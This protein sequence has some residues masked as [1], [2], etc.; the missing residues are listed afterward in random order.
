[1]LL[2]AP[3][4]PPVGLPLESAV[5]SSPERHRHRQAHGQA[6]GQYHGQAQGQAHGQDQGDQS[7]FGG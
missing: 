1:M 5:I 2:E 3:P 7:S 4:S 6:H